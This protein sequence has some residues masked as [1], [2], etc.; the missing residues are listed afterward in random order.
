LFDTFSAS[1]VSILFLTTVVGL[2]RHTSRH[3]Q[4]VRINCTKGGQTC[5]KGEDG[6]GGRGEGM[7][8]KGYSSEMLTVSGSMSSERERG[9]EKNKKKLRGKTCLNVRSNSPLSSFF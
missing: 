2:F 1:C 4:T 5:G 7:K 8:K 3:R 9:R 6:E